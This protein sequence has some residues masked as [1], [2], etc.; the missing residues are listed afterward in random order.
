MKKLLY[1]LL[2]FVTLINVAKSQVIDIK[3]GM[4]GVQNIYLHDG[5]IKYESNSGE[6]PFNT[7]MQF[8]RYDGS[9]QVKA[10]AVYVLDANGSETAIS[11]SI[12]VTTSDFTQATGTY[13]SK[14][15]AKTAK[16]QPNNKAGVVKLK[17]RYWDTYS[18][19]TPK[20]SSY[21]YAS[22]TYQTI[23]YSGI[24]PGPDGRVPIY[25][26]YAQS[27]YDH[28]YSPN[29]DAQSQ[30][31]GW[32]NHGAV[33]RAYYTQEAGS[34]P[35]YMFYAESIK[36]HVYSPD[37]NA[38]SQWPGWVNHGPAFYAY[39]TQVAGSVPVYVFYA[40]SIKDHVYSTNPNAQSQ[41]PGWVNYGVA[42]YAF[43]NLN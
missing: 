37:P 28:V 39:T 34:I 3:I 12:F 25:E 42:F 15:F 1:T 36:D 16:L 26:L 11:D 35:I 27:V 22:K 7:V 20:W 24:I 41:W 13:W 31:P 18:G 40:E 4:W 10:Q 14:E 17:W 32:V 5:K 21:Y 9:T 19:T 2:A 8:Q 30:W 33:F 43:P 29:P 6:T 38:Q 23:L